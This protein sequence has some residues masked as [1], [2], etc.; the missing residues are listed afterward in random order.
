MNFNCEFIGLLKNAKIIFFVTSLTNSTQQLNNYYVSFCIK[1]TFGAKMK[2]KLSYWCQLNIKHKSVSTWNGNW[3]VNIKIEHGWSHLMTYKWSIIIL[4]QP[5]L[6]LLHFH[7]CTKAGSC[8]WSLQI[9]LLSWL[10]GC[11]ICKIAAI[12]FSVWLKR[13]IY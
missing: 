1:S 12:C 10:Y 11:W 2:S 3:I 13:I 8:L 6:R 4:S 9:L 5:Q 7:F